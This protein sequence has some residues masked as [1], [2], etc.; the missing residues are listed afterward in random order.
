MDLQE[1]LKNQYLVDRAE[2][3]KNSEQLTL[4]ELILL[5]EPIVERQEEYFKE[6]K[7]YT[8][9]RF[10]FCEGGYQP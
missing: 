6:H 1:I 4:G 7:Y 3:M 8:I 10:D 9:V 2:K 5:L